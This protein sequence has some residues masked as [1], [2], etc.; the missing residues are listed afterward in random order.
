MVA[1][2]P[3]Q[4]KE[5]SR[6]KAGDE[7]DLSPVS[8]EVRDQH[9]NTS[10]YHPKD[11]LNFSRQSAITDSNQLQDIHIVAHKQTGSG[12]ARAETKESKERQTVRETRWYAKTKLRRK[13][14]G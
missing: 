10:A 7:K 11:V 14:R 5:K 8:Y 2:P 13:Q 1:Y 4:Y 6:G 12:R 9:H 3:P